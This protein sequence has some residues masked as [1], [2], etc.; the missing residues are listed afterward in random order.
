[1]EV[2]PDRTSLESWAMSVVASELAD[3]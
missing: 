2:A 3:I 1:M